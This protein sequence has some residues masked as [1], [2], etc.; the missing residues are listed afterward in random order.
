MK[1]CL[2]LFALMGCV[3]CATAGP[4]AA[5]PTVYAA[6][7]SYTLSAATLA[8]LAE[9]GTDYKLTLSLQS[10]SGGQARSCTVAPALPAPKP[11]A[12]RLVLTR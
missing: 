2:A 3:G 6:D 5:A 10:G 11:L 1:R 4:S 9:A 7:V 12:E 8:E